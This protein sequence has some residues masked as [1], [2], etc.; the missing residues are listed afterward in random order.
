MRPPVMTSEAGDL[1]SSYAAH[2][3][4]AS[5]NTILSM[6]K[7]TPIATTEEAFAY[8]VVSLKRDISVHLQR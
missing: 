3:D 6:A 5:N 4:S 2:M 8:A 1:S 7:R